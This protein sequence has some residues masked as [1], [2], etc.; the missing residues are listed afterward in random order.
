MLRTS[1]YLQIEPGLLIGRRLDAQAQIRLP[2]PALSH[3]R[4]LMGDFL[5]IEALLREAL[6][7]LKAGLL[8]PRVL[9][10]LLPDAEGGYTDVEQR[11]FL[12][13]AR[14]AGAA[15]VRLQ[16]AGAPLSDAEVRDLLSRR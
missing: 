10:H 8:A 13:A 16:L 5:A 12:E 3:P 14:G 15:S 4:T 7:R 9:L 6:A 2:S 1:L 11:A